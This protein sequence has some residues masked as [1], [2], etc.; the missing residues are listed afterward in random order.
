VGG[1]GVVRKWERCKRDEA[2]VR[3]TGK[4]GQ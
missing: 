2:E 4:L 1:G 3:M